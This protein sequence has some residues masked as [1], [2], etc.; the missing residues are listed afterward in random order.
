MRRTTDGGRPRLGGTIVAVLVAIA[1]AVSGCGFVGGKDGDDG[2]DDGSPAPNRPKTAWEKVLDQIGPNG[3]VSKETALAAFSV[4]IAPLPGAKIPDGPQQTI[5]SATG[6]LRWVR[7]HWDDLT[8]EQRTAVEEA[9]QVP[10][11]WLDGGEA[12]RAASR[13]TGAGGRTLAAGIRADNGGGEDRSPPKCEDGEDEQSKYY[14][15]IAEE[16]VGKVGERFGSPVTFDIAFSFFDTSKNKSP[17]AKGAFVTMAATATDEGCVF[18]NGNGIDICA[19][20]A[21]P[22]AAGLMDAVLIRSYI[23]HELVHCFQFAYLE[24]YGGRFL[25][26]WVIEGQAAYGG[27]DVVTTTAGFTAGWWAAYLQKPQTGLFSREYDAVGF[28]AHLKESG[29]DPWSRYKAMLDAAKAGGSGRAFEVALADVKKTFLDTWAAGYFRDG[30]SP[31]WGTDGPGISGL[32]PPIVNRK[33]ADTKLRPDILAIQ[34]DP[35]AVAPAKVDIQV[36]VFTVSGGEYG[37]VMDSKG[38]DKQ[39][40]DLYGIAFCT[41]DTCKC[42]DDSARAG[43]KFEAFPN[44]PTRVAPSG[45]LDF[46]HVKFEGWKLD[47]YCESVDPCLVGAWVA[48]TAELSDGGSIDVRGARG[49]RLSIEAS[50]ESVWDFTPSEPYT[51]TFDGVNPGDST[52]TAKIDG[53]VTSQFR[54][55]ETGVYLVTASG[56]DAQATAEVNGPA[57][58]DVSDMF[59][60]MIQESFGQTGEDEYQC[61]KKKL[62]LSTGGGA[63]EWTFNKVDGPQDNKGKGNRTPKKK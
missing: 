46:G 44:G 37:M 17:N 5:P 36:E 24:V 7:S 43:A 42:P 49:T 40:K 8:S 59:N 32:K 19:I 9:L 35:V 15:D 4:A 63:H 25:P 58:I 61:S 34:T 23:A 20:E 14:N 26:P 13:P 1:L 39:I 10:P 57:K 16:L 28:Y 56:G 52:I 22:P 29:V 53:K 51:G 31:P 50:G 3:E 45:S 2:R 30:N 38:D 6:A 54:T 62:T 18:V 11:G 12:P 27:L 60:G 21:L 48:E 33:F 41:L 55:P 47:E